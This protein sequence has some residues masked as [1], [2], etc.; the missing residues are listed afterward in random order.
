MSARLASVALAALV[1][2]GCAAGPG[3]VERGELPDSP[4]VII[5]RTEADALDRLDALDDLEDRRNP[6]APRQSNRAVAR[7]ESLDGLYGGAPNVNQRIRAFAGRI[8]IVDPRTGDAEFVPDAPS[9]ARPISWSPDR[10]HLLLSGRFR[11]GSQLFVWERAT[12]SVEIVTPGPADHPQGCL[13]PDGH[14]V[15]V[16]VR[17]GSLR[18][19]LLRRRPGGALEPLTRGPW[20]IQPTCSPDG[21][22]V[23]YVTFQGGRVAIA[24]LSLEDPEA[25]PQIVATGKDPAFTPDGAWIVY[26]AQTKQGRRIIRMRP[27][28]TGKIPLHASGFD[29]HQ[30][31]VSPDGRYVAYVVVEHERE[32]L[33]V[34]RLDGS[35]SRPLLDSGDATSPAW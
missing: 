21:K 27:D 4:I 2:G 10:S 6:T 30:P 18:A 35:G 29:E 28:G 12:R 13:G 9:Q 7:L 17:T 33:W 31:A 23:A 19:R 5:Y 34:Q 11:N 32:R 20:D 25:E 24:V 14:L 26:S 15:A 8:A 3:R 16:E 22:R 1:L